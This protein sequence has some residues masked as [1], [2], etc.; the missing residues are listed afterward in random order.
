MTAKAFILNRLRS[1]KFAFRGAWLL[2]RHEPSVQV[3]TGIAVV[4]TIAGLLLHITRMEWLF[5]VLA[6]GLI[7]ALEGMNT[8]VEEIAD[9]VHPDFHVKIGL[10]KD[11]SAGAVTF[12]A[13]A[14]AIIGLIIYVPY[15]VQLFS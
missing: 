3:Q 1:F 15:I 9:F 10:I 2:I 5:Q 14:A 13:I 12:A 11:V 4:M 7:L 6:I 8:A